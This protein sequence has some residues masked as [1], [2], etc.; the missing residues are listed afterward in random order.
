MAEEEHKLS[1]SLPGE[2]VLRK[3]LGPVLSEIGDDLKRLYAKGRDKIVE[4]AYKKIKDPNDGKSANLRIAHDV[5]T[6][7]AFTDEEICAE[8]FGGILASSRTDDG[9][10]DDAIQLLDTIKSL[11]AGQ[12]HLHYVL[13]NSLNKLLVQRVEHI[14]VGQSTEIEAK[15]MWF[16]LQELIQIKIKFDTDFT[17]LHRQGLIQSYQTDTH[18]IDEKRVLPYARTCPTTYGILLY[19]VAHNRLGEWRT[20][21]S[22]QF[23][24]FDGIALPRL[25]A[26]SVKELLL[27]A[28]VSVP[29]S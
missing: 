22:V 16:A 11:S 29:E 13:Y 6:S 17:V 28:G 14:N 18:K 2:W 20:F 10:N 7:G 24:D 27:A 19:A 9:K 26:F 23:P 3:T 1:V 21:S 15:E 25:Y 12:L 5:L 4:K 8:Y